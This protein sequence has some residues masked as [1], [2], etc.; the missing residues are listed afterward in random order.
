V[1]QQRVGK[2]KFWSWDCISVGV[3]ISLDDGESK[4]QDPENELGYLLQMQP[5]ST[6]L[7]LIGEPLRR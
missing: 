4:L 2:I 7:R 3:Q 1:V 6:S 5:I